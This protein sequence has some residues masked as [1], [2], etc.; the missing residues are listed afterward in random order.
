[1]SICVL[2]VA[3]L[4][5]QVSEAKKRADEATEQITQLEEVKKKLQKVLT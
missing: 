5:L 2:Q 3:T 4:T 1:M